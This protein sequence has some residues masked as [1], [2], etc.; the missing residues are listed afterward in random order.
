MPSYGYEDTGLVLSDFCACDVRVGR[1]VLNEVKC[2]AEGNVYLEEHQCSGVCSNGACTA[3]AHEGVAFCYDTDF[4]GRGI[5]LE[6][7]AQVLARSYA[8]KGVNIG[9]YAAAGD[10]SYGLWT[11]SC[12]SEKKLVEYA[13]KLDRTRFSTVTCGS[14]CSEGKCASPPYCTDTDGGVNEKAQGAVTVIKAKG[15]GAGLEM[16]ASVDDCINQR[17]VR[18]YLCN[19]DA[20]AGLIVKECQFG[21]VQG[22]CLK[23]GEVVELPKS[24]TSKDNCNFSQGCLKEAGAA[25]GVCGKC[26]KSADCGSG[27]QCASGRCRPAIGR[28]VNDINCK[29][30]KYC[31]KGPVGQLGYCSPENIRTLE[32]VRLALERRWNRIGIYDKIISSAE[33]LHG[34]ALP[35]RKANGQSCLVNSQCTSKYCNPETSKCEAAGATPRAGVNDLRN[36]LAVRNVPAPPRPGPIIPRP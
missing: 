21:C 5:G 6:N 1:K 27:W 18:E 9:F 14:G 34:L 20:S 30:G 8:T 2:N 12:A 31:E 7:S 23:E 26:T 35:V 10:I 16:T 15:V 11:D 32:G 22:R 24:C 17:S 25:D 13:C 33:S 28:C 29:L 19:D 4:Q 36:T 3:V